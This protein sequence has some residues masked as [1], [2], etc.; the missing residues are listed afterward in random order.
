[1]YKYKQF[2]DY[3]WIESKTEKYKIKIALNLFTPHTCVVSDASL[4]SNVK[5]ICKM[6]R[7]LDLV[8]D[9]F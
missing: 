3:T 2:H 9:E 1:M 8:Y 5:S 4:R 6:K 7:T